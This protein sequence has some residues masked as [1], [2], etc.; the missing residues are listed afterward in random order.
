MWQ[1]ENIGLKKNRNTY[2]GA[3]V[4]QCKILMIFVKWL[5]SP[6]VNN[7]LVFTGGENRDFFYINATF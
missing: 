2:L 7:L 3:S 6:M 4:M 1:V 5:L